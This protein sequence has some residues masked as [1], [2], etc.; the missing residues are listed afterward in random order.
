MI[1]VG[2]T[3]KYDRFASFSN[4]GSCVTI[5]GPGVDV[6]SALPQQQEGFMSGTSMATPV[7]A[8]IVAAIASEYPEFDSYRMEEY[9]LSTSTRGT[10]RELPPRTPNVLSFY[11]RQD[12]A[13]LESAC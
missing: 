11:G 1:V 8:G 6:L 5:S 13:V 12:S 3:D 9:L 2:A 7:V 10:L 4:H